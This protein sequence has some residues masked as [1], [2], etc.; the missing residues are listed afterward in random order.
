MQTYIHGVSINPLTV[1]SLQLFYQIRYW[2]RKIEVVKNIVW[3]FQTYASIGIFCENGGC[4][5]PTLFLKTT[6][7]HSNSQK[8]IYF[9]GKVFFSRVEL[10]VDFFFFLIGFVCF[11][12]LPCCSYVALREF[13]LTGLFSACWKMFCDIADIAE[14]DTNESRKTQFM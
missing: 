10:L 13:I 2:R 5:G 6:T 1:N 9:D 4:D 7:F 8:I 11:F 14:W 12:F 3:N